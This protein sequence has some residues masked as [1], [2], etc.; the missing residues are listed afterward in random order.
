MVSVAVPDIGASAWAVVIAGASDPFDP[1]LEDAEQQVL[2]AGYD[3]TITNCDVGAATALG[4]A[5]DS[6]FTVSV[7]AADEQNASVLA[8]AL[9]AA[10]LAGEIAEIS[11]D[12]G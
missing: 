10:G 2:N 5:P 11:V 6:S 7:Y 4:M 9:D 8:T 1:P 3:T 12:C